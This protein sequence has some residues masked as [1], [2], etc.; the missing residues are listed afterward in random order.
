MKAVILDGFL[1]HSETS[2][3]IRNAIEQELGNNLTVESF[4]LRDMKI[5][6]CMGCFGCWV[7]TPGTCVMKDDSAK[8]DKALVSS[9]LLIFLTPITFGGYSSELKK[10]ADRMLCIL[11]PFFAT[12]NGETHHKARYDKFPK[13]MGIGVLPE[14]DKEK[15]QIFAELVRRN[16]VN[17][18]TAAHCAG[19]LRLNQSVD[20]H[21]QSIRNY[22]QSVMEG[23]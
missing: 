7:K 1:Q 20:E 13:F 6:H 2:E 4:V 5:V 23:K 10:A 11:S 14:H 19:I 8:I 15:E 21:R 9:D 18:H 16:A 3:S 22:F 17:F 12:I